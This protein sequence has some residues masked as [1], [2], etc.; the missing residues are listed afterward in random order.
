M[1]RVARLPE[2]QDLSPMKPTNSNPMTQSKKSLNTTMDEVFHREAVHLNLVRLHHPV[3]CEAWLKIWEEHGEGT[4]PRQWPAMPYSVEQAEY[5]RDHMVSRKV[6]KKYFER[7][8]AELKKNEPF[9]DHMV[10]T[11]KETAPYQERPEL[12][13]LPRPHRRINK[14]LSPRPSTN[15]LLASMGLGPESSDQSEKT[16]KR[17]RR[18]RGG[19]KH[20]SRNQKNTKDSHLQDV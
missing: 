5:F 19:R 18:P 9:V 17:R 14:K 4:R 6:Y 7:A 16:S 1:Q 8:V 15:A 10:M 11:M 2:R 13:Q 12:M 20:K 3:L